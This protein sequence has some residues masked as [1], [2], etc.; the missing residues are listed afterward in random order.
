MRTGLHQCIQPVKNNRRCNS[1]NRNRR[2]DVFIHTLPLMILYT[3]PVKKRLEIIGISVLTQEGISKNIKPLG[4]FY[5]GMIYHEAVQKLQFLDSSLRFRC[6]VVM[7]NVRPC[8]FFIG[9]F[10]L[11]KNVAAAGNHRHPWRV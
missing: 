4:L 8:T 3:A 7:K 6:D 9:E 2:Y 5:K 10:L 1:Y 11:C